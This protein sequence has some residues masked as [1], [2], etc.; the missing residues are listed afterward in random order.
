MFGGHYR[1]DVERR[2]NNLREKV[3]RDAREQEEQDRRNKERALDWN[4]SPDLE[5]CPHCGSS[6]LTPLP[7]KE[8]QNYPRYHCA[9]CTTSVSACE[10]TLA[11]KTR[12]SSEVRERLYQAFK[13]GDSFKRAAS[14]VGVNKN[15][16]EIWYDKFRYAENYKDSSNVESFHESKYETTNSYATHPI[17]KNRVDN[18]T[19]SEFIR[20]GKISE[21]SYI[22][23]DG[24]VRDGMNRVVDNIY[25]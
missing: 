22:D 23:K 8:G 13:R 6:R 14:D 20:K 11:S 17:Y 21:N 5:T 25:E 19:T 12:L 1:R 4:P 16:V 3:A 24:N 9:V 15:T 7:L 2:N 18:E 10:G